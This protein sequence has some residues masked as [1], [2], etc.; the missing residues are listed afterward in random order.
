ML[1]RELADVVSCGWR[2]LV[3]YGLCDTCEWRFPVLK[4]A[5]YM[6]QSLQTHL[7][8]TVH[9]SICCS[10]LYSTWRYQKWTPLMSFILNA[11]SLY[12]SLS[13]HHVGTSIS[14]S[15]HR[16]PGADQKIGMTGSVVLPVWANCCPT[17][18]PMSA[19]Q[20]NAQSA[21]VSCCLENHH[22]Y[23]VKCPT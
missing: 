14:S 17:L 20:P 1:R 23:H 8:S 3:A 18:R 11:S 4:N 13:Q 2:K 5:R 10:N 9:S 19:Q 7:S 6:N 22:H 15:R 21:W 16:P 12:F